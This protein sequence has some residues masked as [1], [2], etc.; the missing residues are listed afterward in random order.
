MK[1][2][3]YWIIKDGIEIPAEVD[4]K[5]FNWKIMKKEALKKIP[6]IP[7]TSKVHIYMHSMIKMNLTGFFQ[8]RG[9]GGQCHL[10]N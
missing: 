8:N 3:F 10:R 6:Q 5:L 2:Q 4:A 9:V 7:L 1:F